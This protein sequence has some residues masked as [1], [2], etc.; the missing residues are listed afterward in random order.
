MPENM[1]SHEL[2]HAL[3]A[4]AEFLLSQP[5]FATPSKTHSLYLGS[6]W[7]DKDALVA[8][9][10]AVGTVTKEYN[11]SDLQVNVDTPVKIWT[12]INR[13]KVCRKVQEAKWECEPLLKPEEVEAL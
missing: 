7:D 13:D 11:G 6:Y 12:R 9:V 8:M 10:K 2:A 1:K 3:I 5:E 4:T